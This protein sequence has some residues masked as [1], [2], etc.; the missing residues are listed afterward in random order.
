MN[1]R[2]FVSVDTGNPEVIRAVVDAGA[3]MINDVFAALAPGGAL[4]A[5]RESG[6]GVSPVSCTCRARRARC[7]TNPDYERLPGD[8]VATWQRA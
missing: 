7:R 4:Q 8:V 6:A 3:Q 5:A 2:A 1:H